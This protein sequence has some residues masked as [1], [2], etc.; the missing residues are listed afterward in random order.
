MRL[1]AMRVRHFRNLAIQELEVPP[2][3]VAILGENAHG[4]TNFLEAIYYLET[5]RSFRASRDDELVA[6]GEDVF[7]VSATVGDEDVACEVTAAF[8]KH[9]RRKKVAVDGAEPDRLSDALGRVAAVIFSPSDVAIISGGPGERRRFLDIVLSLNVPGYLDSLQRFRHVLAQRNA[10]AREAALE[11]VLRAWD[12]PLAR[13]GAEV[14]V[15]R[16]RWVARYGVAFSSGHE[17]V[18]DGRRARL[19]YEPGVSVDGASSLGDVTQAYAQALERSASTDVRMRATTTGPQRDELGVFI[20]EEEGVWSDVRRYG[21]GGQRRTVVLALRLA[22][23]QTIRDAR[24]RQP[25]MLL[26]DVFAELDQRRSERVLDLMERQ[27]SGQVI[28]T[29]PK[30]SDVRVRRQSLTRWQ[31]RSGKIFA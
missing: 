20:E 2:E 23:A 22:E 29:A 3:G 28:L 8:Q 26:D 4:K 16:T 21:S 18:A 17:A 5:F 13:A 27:A 6:F 9:G 19:D 11:T 15:A 24:C 12:E 1:K 31:I 14:I 7:R 30:E 25:M 10:A